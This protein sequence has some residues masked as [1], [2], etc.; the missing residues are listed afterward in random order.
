MIAASRSPSSPCGDAGESGAVCSVNTK[1]Q[2]RMLR[3]QPAL[4]SRS[5]AA[6]NPDLYFIRLIFNGIKF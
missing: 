5:G 2:T 1:P 6:E 4:Q 3:V